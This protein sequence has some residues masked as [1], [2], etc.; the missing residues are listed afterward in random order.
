MRTYAT[1]TGMIGENENSLIPYEA[2]SRGRAEQVR[3]G[4]EIN[5]VDLQHAF[6]HLTLQ[7]QLTREAHS[8]LGWILDK[9]GKSTMAPIVG[10]E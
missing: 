4:T 10:E 3:N 8:K 2:Y 9:Q 1:M 5:L 6:V 7:E